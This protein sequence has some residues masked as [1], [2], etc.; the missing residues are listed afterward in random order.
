M[1][2]N[3]YENALKACVLRNDD[4]SREII[5]LKGRIREL[6]D[7]IEKTIDGDDSSLEL[8]KKV[9]GYKDGDNSY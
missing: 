4:L 9:I 1:F 5:K 8:L 6:E 7:S 2:N 3:Y